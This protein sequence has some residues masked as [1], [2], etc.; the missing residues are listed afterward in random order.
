[1]GS[2]VTGG[3]VNFLGAQFTG[4]QVNFSRAKLI[5]GLVDFSE[6]RDWSS[7]PL[8]PDWGGK[9]PPGVLLPTR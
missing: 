9:P 1:M 5:G 4:S 6:P 2:K 8:F 3:K 7:P